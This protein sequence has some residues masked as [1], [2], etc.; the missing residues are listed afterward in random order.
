MQ[1]YSKK[2]GAVIPEEKRE[3]FRSRAEKLFQAGGMM[4]LEQVQ[5]CGREVRTL[6]KAAMHSYGM[7]FYYN[8]FEDDCWENAG[9]SLEDYEVWSGKIGW[10][11][12]HSVVVAAYVLECHYLSGA[13]IP[14]V[15]GELV[16]SNQYTAWINYLFQEHYQQKNRDPWPLFEALHDQIDMD[17]SE[18]DWVRF[19]QDAYGL[20]GYYEIQAVLSGTDIADKEF[21]IEKNHKETG[22]EEGKLNFFDFIRGLKSSIREYHEE[23]KQSEKEQLTCIMELLHS[24]YEQDNMSSDISKKYGNPSLERMCIF[25]ALADAPAYAVKVA[26]ETYGVEFWEL[27]E[28]VKDVAK[29]WRLLYGEMESKETISCSTMDFFGIPSDDMI[30]FWGEDDNIQFSSE[31]KGWFTD[32]RIRF[33]KLLELEHT[34]DSPLEWILDLMEYADEN[35]YRVYTFSGF[36]K[37]TIEHLKDKRF[38]ALWKIYDEMLHNPEMEE[39]GSVVFVPEGPE[40]EHVGLHYFGTPPRRRLKS[41][42]DMMGKEKRNN[43]ARVIFRRYMALLENRKL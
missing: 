13:A 12:F 43:K 42:W 20:I 24:F 25:T 15:N 32:L 6:K 35:Y 2:K 8:Y 11:E 7:N 36:F 38:L 27:W 4:E 40:Y 16:T 29:R 41:N 18:H 17:L 28:Q 3:E 22:G 14:M 31:L 34:V 39:A 37:E 30:L 1:Y 19:V 9:F 5:L 21:D 10:Q 26:A 23:S 33:E